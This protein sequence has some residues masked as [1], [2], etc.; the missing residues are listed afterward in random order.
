VAFVYPLV[1]VVVQQVLNFLNSSVYVNGVTSN[2]WNCRRPNLC[3]LPPWTLPNSISCPTATVHE[4]YL[5]LDN[6]HDYILEIADSPNHVGVI[7]QAV[8][9]NLE[10]SVTVVLV[11]PQGECLF[12][13][14]L[15]THLM[16]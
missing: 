14:F 11:L 6:R 5:V 13:G 8:L 3:L 15:V 10:Y 12:S 4:G 2:C 1:V 16:L 9:S 7:H